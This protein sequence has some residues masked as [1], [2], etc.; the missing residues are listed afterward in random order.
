MTWLKPAGRLRGGVRLRGGKVGGAEA[1]NE[2]EGSIL[3]AK[4]SQETAGSDFRLLLVL[5]VA[6]SLTGAGDPG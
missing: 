4:G 2:I 6:R 5:L 3:K 1:G